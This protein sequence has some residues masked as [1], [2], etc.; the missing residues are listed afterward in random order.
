MADRLLRPAVADDVL[1][2][3]DDE[4]RFEQAKRLGFA[5]VEVV[6]APGDLELAATRAQRDALRIRA[7]RSNKSF[8]DGRRGLWVFLRVVRASL[9]V[10]HGA[11]QNQRLLPGSSGF[12]SASGH[13]V[14]SAGVEPTACEAADVVR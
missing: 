1:L 11:F 5:G 4:R 8:G 6:L 9:S 13:F 7:G 12:L 3:A 2:V 14:K 10:K